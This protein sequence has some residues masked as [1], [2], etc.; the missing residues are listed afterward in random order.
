ML[1]LLLAALTPRPRDRPAFVSD[2]NKNRSSISSSSSNHLGLSVNAAHPLPS[3]VPVVRER[4]E[5][6]TRKK[7]LGV[8]LPLFLQVRLLC[9][10]HRKR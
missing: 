3:L 8:G 10:K 9:Q 6:G 7:G 4:G 5:S 1:L 2:S